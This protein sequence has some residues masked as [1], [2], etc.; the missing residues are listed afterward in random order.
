MFRIRREFLGDLRQQGTLELA[1]KSHAAL[2][3]LH[4][5]L[6][7][8]V[9]ITNAAEIFGA[10]RH[11]KS[12]VSLDGADHLLLQERDAIYAGRLIATWVGEGTS[13]ARLSADFP[14]ESIANN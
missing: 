13:R 14:G 10:A 7:T 12:F 8:T 6:D 4:S 3:V 11:P 2:L 1:R 9:D 5:P